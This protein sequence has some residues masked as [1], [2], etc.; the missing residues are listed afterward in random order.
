MIHDLGMGINDFNVEMGGFELKK[1][2]KFDRLWKIEQIDSD[3]G[4]F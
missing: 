1:V 2:K 4:A 3:E